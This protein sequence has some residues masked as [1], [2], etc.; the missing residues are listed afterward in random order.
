V[1]GVLLAAGVR[2]SARF[3]AAIV[4]I[5]LAAI[6]VFI[7]VA[8][9]GVETENWSD[10]TPFGWNGIVGGAALVFFA[11]IGFDAVS[12]AADEARDPQRGLPRGIIGSLVVC[13]AL[14]VV[15]S[16]L[17]TLIADYR[18]LNVASPVSA[19]LLGL[20]VDWAASIVAAGAIAGLTSVMLVLYYGQTRIFFA[21]S[22][23]GLLPGF[24]G[25]VNPVSRSPVKVILVCGFFMALLA[26]FLPL[27]TIAE[28]VNIGTL[29]A[30]VLVCLG[31][32]AL[33]YRQPNLKR[34][35]R[36]PGGPV[37]PVLGALA[38][39]YLMSQL[40]AATWLR[41]VIWMLFG[42]VVYFSYSRHRSRLAAAPGA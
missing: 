16:G 4:F 32:L 25:E 8:V 20:G 19:A 9:G 35:F 21:M 6:A 18:T 30:F 23:D 38:C 40:P 27:T 29:A 26:G 7:V 14:Y 2:A 15:V 17:L 5:K 24:F 22:R 1:L 3:N 13:T 11:F 31:V 41:F 37:V 42:T 10:F 28:L 33:R 12:T 34:P 39:L 36:A